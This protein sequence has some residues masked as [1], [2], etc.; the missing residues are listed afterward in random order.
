MALL[1]PS[2]ELHQ[3]QEWPGNGHRSRVLGGS[4]CSKCF[5]PQPRNYSPGRAQRLPRVLLPDQRAFV[6]EWKL[7]E[8]P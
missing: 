5:K 6:E 3:P 4:R 7:H 8:M 1:S 2:P